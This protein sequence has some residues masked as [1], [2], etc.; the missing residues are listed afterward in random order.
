MRGVYASP[1]SVTDRVYIAGRNGTTTVIKHGPKFELLASNTLD[2]AST[3]SPAIID[4]EIYLR[5][6]THLHC[7]MEQ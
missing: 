2:D 3:A 4:S 7:I 6:H 1:V 5:G